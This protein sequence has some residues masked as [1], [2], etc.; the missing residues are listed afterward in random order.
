VE[1]LVREREANGRF[2]GLAD[3]AA[4]LD[5]KA[6]N[7]R[8]LENLVCAGALDGLN[9]N[10]RQSFEAIETILR[11]A[12]AAANER[13]SSQVNLF[14]A[15]DD[16]AGPSLTLPQV[17]DW[18]IMERLHKEFEAIGF[19]LSA[20][21][22]DAYGQSLKRLEVVPYG[23]LPS[24]L[25]T[26]TGSRAKLAGIV[27]ARQERTSA[28]GNRFAFVQMSDTTG[29]FE[30]LVFSD[31]LATTRELLEPGRIVLLTA[32]VRAEED[33][34]R[35]TVQAVQALDDAVAQSGAG[36]RIYLRDS[37]PIPSLKQLI[38][39]ERRGKGKISFVL[40]LDGGREV[41]MALKETYAVSAPTR[42]AIKAVPGIVEVQDL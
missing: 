13:N 4:R 28:K 11:Q 3:L 10:R 21:P 8:P 35:L 9:R 33:N 40:D 7:K 29:M 19:Y 24:W 18:P 6:L 22:L 34:L 27:I 5:A 30:A 12:N 20:H 17:P 42:A 2:A 15:L 14:G 38:V 37:E 36:L 41:E 26:R 39:R 31:T 23:D 25:K 16:G 32:D 1:T